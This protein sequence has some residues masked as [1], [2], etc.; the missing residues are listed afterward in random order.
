[1][2]KLQCKRC[3]NE[4]LPRVT[5]VKECP[6]C[7]SR[8]WN[9]IKNNKEISENILEDNKELE[10]VSEEGDVLE[11]EEAPEEIKEVPEVKT[12]TCPECK[13]HVELYQDCNNCGAELIWKE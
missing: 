9:I 10:Q 11:I 13:S 4:W 12:F 3:Q 7:K 6:K 8:I 1:M 2:E 5:Y